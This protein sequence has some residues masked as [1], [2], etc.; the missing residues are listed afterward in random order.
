MLEWIKNIFNNWGLAK[1]AMTDPVE[2]GGELTE[3]ILSKLS[4]MIQRLVVLG[5]IIVAMLLGADMGID[6]GK[7]QAL[8]S[9]APIVQPVNP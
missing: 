3:G 4:P 9:P 5:L 2:T 8:I 7:K 6:Y 1:D